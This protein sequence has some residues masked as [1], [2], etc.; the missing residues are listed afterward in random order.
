MNPS[1]SMYTQI[2]LAVCERLI[3]P[4]TADD[5]SRRGV[6]NVLSL[7]YGMKLPSE[8]Y[9]QHNFH[10]RMNGAVIRLPKIHLV[11]KNRLTQYVRTA[12]GYSAVLDGIQ[13]DLAVVH[14]NN[15]EYFTFKS[16]HD[17]MIEIRDFQTAGVV[18][19][20]RGTP[21]STMSSGTLSVATQRVQVNRDQLIENQKIV[22]TLAK[23]LW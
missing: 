11:A 6:Q 1:F 2:A 16:V 19:F 7:I 4:V 23:G 20:A 5:S 9:S 17:G 21:F 22:D 14:K 3:L 13:N 12:K 8:I 15:P 18:A 10:T